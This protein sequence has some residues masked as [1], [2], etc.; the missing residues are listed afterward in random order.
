MFVY[1]LLETTTASGDWFEAEVEPMDAHQAQLNNYDRQAVFA[2]G[3]S[4]IGRFLEP[5]NLETEF[6]P[7]LNGTVGHRTGIQNDVPS[8]SPRKRKH[9]AEVEERAHGQF[10]K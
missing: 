6:L 8:S 4:E 1:E 9:A 10:L 7:F 3:V 5:E 2:P